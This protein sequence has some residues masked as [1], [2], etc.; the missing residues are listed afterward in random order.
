VIECERYC[1]ATYPGT[2]EGPAECINKTCYCH[3]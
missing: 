2:F 1:R 3:V